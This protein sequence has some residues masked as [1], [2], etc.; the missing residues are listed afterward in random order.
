MKKWDM[1]ELQESIWKN[2][3]QY[4]NESYDEWLSRVSGGDREVSELIEKKRFIFGGRILANRGLEKEGKKVTYS[5]CFTEGTKVITSDGIKNIEDIVE[6]DK[7]LTHTD[8]FQDV[9]AIMEREY[10]GEIYHIKMNGYNDTIHCTPNHKFLTTNGWVSASELKVGKNGDF[11][12]IAKSQFTTPEYEI[13]LDQYINTD[14]NTRIE[15]L[16]DGHIK[17]VCSYVGGNGA[18]GEKSSNSAKN[19]VKITDDVKYLFGVW[20]GDGSVTRRDKCINNSIWQI[21]FNK[22]D[23]KNYEKCKKILI[24]TFGIEPNTTVMNEK[25]NTIILRMD[26]PIVGEFFAKYLG[27]YC[28]GKQIPKELIGDFNI[29]KGILDSDGVVTQQQSIKLQLKNRKLLEQVKQSLECNG[30]YTNEIKE[31]CTYLKETDKTYVGYKIN[32]S[33]L[34]SREFLLPYLTKKYKDKRMSEK[35]FNKQIC[36]EENDMFLK[37]KSIETT[38]KDCTVYNIS[39][40]KDHSYSVNGI[41]A[42]NCYVMPRPEDNLESIFNTARDLARTFSYGGGV[43][44]DISNLSP[45]GAKVNNTAEST[46]GAVSF[47][48]LYDMVTS[49]I[50]QRGRRAALM[51]SLDVN[52]PDI[53]MFIDKKTDLDAITKANISIRVDDNF[54]KKATSEDSDPIYKC[55]FYRPETNETIEKEIDAKDLFEKLCYNN[56]DYAEPGILFWDNIENYN[57]LSEDQNFEYA[58][59]NPCA[60]EPLPAG[61]SCLLGSFNL[62]EYVTIS[63]DRL[64]RNTFNGDKFKEDIHKVVR[65]MNDVLDEG[66]P[67]H[68]L[69][70]Q[71]DTVKNYRQI[72]IGVMGIA[73]MLIKMGIRYGSD[74]SLEL[75]EKISKTLANES[76]KA[77]ALLAKES[78]AYPKYNETILSTVFLKENADKETF[79][80]IK[81]YGL[82]NSQLL[83]IAPTGSL[84]TMWGISGGIEPIFAFSYTRKTESLHDEDVYYKVYTPIVQDYMNKHNITKEENLPDFFINA[85]KLKPI[86]R[87]NMQAVWQKHIDASISSTVNLPEE[88]TVDQVK[89]LY[90]LAW[91]N[92]LKGLTV[93]RE[94]CKRMGI[95]TTKEIEEEVDVEELTEE[96]GL[97]RGE[98]KDIAKDTYYVKRKINIGCGSLVLFIGYSPSEGELQEFFIKKSGSGGCDKNLE[99]TVIAM[100]VIFRLGGTLDMIES[101]FS[102]VSSC[103]SFATARAKGKVISRGGYCGS[104]IL[105]AIKDFLQEIE[106]LKPTTELPSLQR[107]NPFEIELVELSNP[108]KADK[109]NVKLYPCPECGVGLEMSEGCQT[110]RSCGYSKCN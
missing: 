100:S 56:W 23:Y 59:V 25:Q 38:Q 2:K 105:N 73:D 57:L 94:G 70:I 53:E 83:T 44:I 13:K 12:K 62:S 47:M 67:L 92:K 17:T 46:T 65:A 88:A 29:I 51:I 1:N 16:D 37:I 21:V 54:M 26:N 68:P 102:G 39:V 103:P 27:K 89:E 7:V 91:K 24:D 110:C 63:K 36:R 109:Q 96:L 8:V 98:K 43:G 64:S 97:K 90:T 78:G 10:I 61:G 52:H 72:G 107:E 3:Y 104:A 55:V 49:L 75:C 45:N 87:I 50:G 35:R 76:L 71:R 69:Q 6:G 4:N 66:L 60:E 77:S 106:Q 5:N 42:H 108:I 99:T 33:S 41:I 80:L 95:L 18:K 82:R 74:L 31:V 11:I 84:S 34:V 48:D 9:N 81:K 93:F 101:A 28:D 40:E 32:I 85:A 20:L 14:S 58:G 86:D 19:V 15:Y 22:K 79:E 30:I